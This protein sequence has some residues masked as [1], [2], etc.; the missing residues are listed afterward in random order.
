MADSTPK[1]YST[2]PALYLYTSLTAGSSHIITATSRLETIL[3]A[4]KIPFLALDV[5][6]DE[7]A[8]ML[9]GRRAGKRKLPGL[10]K[11][12]MVVGDLEEVEEWNEYGELKD[13]I[14]PVPG[15]MAT[16][17]ASAQVT[18][19]KPSLQPSVSTPLDN[20]EESKPAGVTG[21]VP[22]PFNAAMRQVGEEAAQKAKQ[23]KTKSSNEAIAQKTPSMPPASGET[24]A[25][26]DNSAPI[27]PPSGTTDAISAAAPE[28]MDSSSHS[29]ADTT[30]A[31]TQELA[32]S[33][34]SIK[35]D[36][37]DAPSGAITQN[38]GSNVGFASTEEIEGTEKSNALAEKNESEVAAG[39]FIGV[40][41]PDSAAISVTS[42]P[43]DARE[44]TSPG[45]FQHRGSNVSMASAEEIRDVEQRNAIA[46]EDEPEE[47]G[48]I[49]CLSTRIASTSKVV[50]TDASQNLPGEKTQRQ[51]AA[52][53]N[54]AGD[55]VAD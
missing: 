14:G 9:W 55:S 36:P 5:A 23:S 15:S 16:P 30:G 35:S 37:L 46:E 48:G 27:P 29:K 1:S 10:V 44:E 18:P 42:L 39:P 20:K 24:M 25:T 3:K 43:I 33:T 47:E 40:K 6:T 8:R 12:G 7:K 4:N 28:T 52:N 2:D 32:P 11:M 51:A 21:G 41:A 45:R 31:V 22:T 38:H 17:S 34:T 50:A 19:S 26:L 49:G 54:L 53:E 13:N